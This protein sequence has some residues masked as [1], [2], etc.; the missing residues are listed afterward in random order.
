MTTYVDV[1]LFHADWCGHCKN[2]RPEWQSLKDKISKEKNNNLKLTTH[3][4]KDND[5]PPEGATINGKEIDGYPTIKVTVTK[6]TNKKE[7]DYQGKRVANE[8]YYYLTKEVV[9]QV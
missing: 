8:L 9:K 1:T 5:L 3:E 2:F 6:G 4:Y 7:I